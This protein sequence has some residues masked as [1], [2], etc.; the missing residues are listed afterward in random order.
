M[1]IFGLS[2][3]DEG[4]SVGFSYD[5]DEKDGG[6]LAVTRT[7]N[8][9]YDGPYVDLIEDL[10]GEIE[11]FIDSAVHMYDAAP[12]FSPDDEDEDDEMMGSG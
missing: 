11:S 1:K 6:R 3:S 12:E 5:N 7:L 4:V 2:F 9:A 10:K 8:M